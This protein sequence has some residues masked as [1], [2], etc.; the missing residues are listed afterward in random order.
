VNSTGHHH[1]SGGSLPIEE[2]WSFLD[3]R[4][5]QIALTCALH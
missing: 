4:V 5:H 2:P 3:E 1:T